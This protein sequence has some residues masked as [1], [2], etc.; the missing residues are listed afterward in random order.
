MAPAVSIIRQRHLRQ[1]PQQLLRL[2]IAS[3]P[4]VVPFRRLCGDAT[5]PVRGSTCATPAACTAGSTGSSVPCFA[6][7]LVRQLQQHQWLRTVR[8]RY[9]SNNN[10]NTDVLTITRHIIHI[11]TWQGHLSTQ[12]KLRQQTTAISRL[13]VTLLSPSVFCASQRHNQPCGNDIAINS[14]VHYLIVF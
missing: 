10:N 3:A 11:T 1:L 7:Q 4:T 12:R 9:S 13:L 5:V 8:P 14:A 6:L 2:S